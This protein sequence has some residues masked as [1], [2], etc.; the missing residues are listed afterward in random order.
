MVDAAPTTI[1]AVLSPSREDA[2]VLLGGSMSIAFKSAIVGRWTRECPSLADLFD[3]Y[4]AVYVFLESVTGELPGRAGA[5]GIAAAFVRSAESQGYTADRVRIGLRDGPCYFTDRTGTPTLGAGDWEKIAG[6]PAAT[7]GCNVDELRGFLESLLPTPE[8][9]S[10]PVTI[11]VTAGHTAE[12][13]AA[14]TE[15]LT[16]ATASI[17]DDNPFYFTAVTPPQEAVAILKTVVEANTAITRGLGYYYST[18]S[19]PTLTLPGKIVY[20]FSG[21]EFARPA[22]APR[23]TLTRHPPPAPRVDYPHWAARY[24]AGLAG[25]ARRRDCV[26]HPGRP[27]HGD[28]NRRNQ[29]SRQ[30]H[31]C[32]G[33]R[34]RVPESRTVHCLKRPATRRGR[35]PN[36][37]GG[38]GGAA[39]AA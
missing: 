30:C 15:L 39:A 6:G 32:T 31:D 34:S 36:Y 21:R 25:H 5:A 38:G 7:A 22:P 9:A 1:P 12:I 14:R 35:G 13:R 17:Y 3:D 11:S 27:L 10:N 33:H 37:C 18:E 29:R 28:S 4:A 20:G 16:I 24:W 19:P 8:A 23:P 2:V 26:A